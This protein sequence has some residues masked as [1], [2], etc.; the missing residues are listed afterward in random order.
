MIPSEWTAV[1]FLGLRASP[2]RF[3][4]CIEPLRFH[5][6]VSMP[7]PARHGRFD[8]LRGLANRSAN[9][10]ITALPRRFRYHSG[11]SVSPLPVHVL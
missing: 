1:R 6:L 8:G 5:P 7:I 11:S 2:T 10:T 3:D 9:V 4:E